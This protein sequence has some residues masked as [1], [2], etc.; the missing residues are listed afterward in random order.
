M[1]LVFL[2]DLHALLA[3]LVHITAGAPRRS[4]LLHYFSYPS[5]L[6]EGEAAQ[7]ALPLTDSQTVRALSKVAKKWRRSLPHGLVHSHTFI[8]HL[9]VKQFGQ[10]AGQL[11]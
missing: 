8:L 5:L 9:L 11:L 3:A 6:G 10:T 1:F 2:S 7:I 4:S